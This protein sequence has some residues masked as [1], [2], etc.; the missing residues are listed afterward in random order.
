MGKIYFDPK[1]NPATRMEASSRF[2]CGAAVGLLFGALIALYLGPWNVGWA[3]TAIVVA[4]VGFGLLALYFGE[5]FW[6]LL[7]RAVSALPWF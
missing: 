2:I 5:D 4:A 7:Q 3:V 1:P 6:D